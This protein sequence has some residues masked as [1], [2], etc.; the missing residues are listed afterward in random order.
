MAKIN[1]LRERDV[2]T[3]RLGLDGA[4]PRS[5]TD[6]AAKAGMSRAEIR[7]VESRALQRLITNTSPQVVDPW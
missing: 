5:L 3:Q 4:P 7:R 6:V 1:S 2:L